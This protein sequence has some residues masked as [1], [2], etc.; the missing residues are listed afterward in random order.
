MFLKRIVLSLFC[1]HVVLGKTPEIREDVRKFPDGFLFGVASASYQVEGAWDED[2]KSESIWDHDTHK[3]PSPIDDMSTGDIADDSYHLYKRDVEMVREMGVDFYR[4]SLSWT[5]IMPTSFPDKINQ[6]GVDYYNNLINEL[7]KHNIKPMITLFHWDM[8]QKLQEMGGWTNPNIVD[9]YGDYVRTAYELFGDRVKYW[10]TINEPTQI[11]LYGYGLNLLA[12]R[13]N[14]PGVADYLCSKNLLLA[15]ARAYHIYDEEFRASQGGNISITLSAQWYEPES[16]LY[17]TASREYLQFDSGVYAHPI[18]SKEGDWPSIVK[19]KVAR[20][21]AE[22]GFARSRLPDFT[23]EEIEYV[24]G[25]SDFFGLNHYSSYFVNM[26]EDT[27]NSYAVPSRADDIGVNVFKLNEWVLSEFSSTDYVPWGFYKL[28]NYFRE[29]YDNPPIFITEN[30]FGT[31]YTGLD[32]DERVT[33]YRGYIGAVL[34]AID[35]GTNI[36]GYTAWCLMDNFEWTKGYTV[37]YGIYHVDFESPNRTRTPRKSAFVYK[38]IVRTRSLDI[39][40]E[41]DT[42]VMTIDEGH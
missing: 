28:L 19:E 37:R 15:H 33:Y 10:I 18:F 3:I 2:G 35:D 29:E 27:I 8:P 6:A 4:I 13:L 42:S 12:P 5:R 9:W 39:G 20:K 36:I 23:P 11:C 41:P 32:D 34:D 24:R 14:I 1:F 25:T 22:Q 26:D 16:E 38:E 21:S 40:F 30:G 17:A 31:Y 7:L